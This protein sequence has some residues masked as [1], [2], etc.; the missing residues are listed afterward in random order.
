MK[1]V[2]VSHLNLYLGTSIV[3]PLYFFQ[4]FEFSRQNY[5]N[6]QLWISETILSYFQ[7]QCWNN[8]SKNS[9][10]YKNHA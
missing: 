6:Y 8:V 10:C 1:I 3:W 5:Q 4:I 7:T 2:K 9:K